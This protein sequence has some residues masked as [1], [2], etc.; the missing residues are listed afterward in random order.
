[1]YLDSV[2]CCELNTLSLSY[3]LHTDCVSHFHMKYNCNKFEVCRNLKPK[4]V[5]VFCLS[6]YTSFFLVLM[7]HNSPERQKIM[8]LLTMNLLG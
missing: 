2:S 1:M 8:L 5:I 6:Q 3:I 4:V 7:S